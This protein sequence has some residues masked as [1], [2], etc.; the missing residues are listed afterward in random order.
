MLSVARAA[1]ASTLRLVSAL[2]AIAAHLREMAEGRGDLT[3]RVEGLSTRELI[4]MGGCFNRFVEAL[5]RIVA[6]IRAGAVVVSTAAEQVAATSQLLSEG[7]QRQAM[8]VTETSM[9]LQKISAAIAKSA[10]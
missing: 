9:S 1:S 10:E 2:F 7:A 6:D 4:E 3:R 5:A 8:S